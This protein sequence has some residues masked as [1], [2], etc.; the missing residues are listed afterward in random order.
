M[1]RLTTFGGVSLQVGGEAGGAFE[2]R[3][4]PRRGLAVLILL[5]A[6]PPAGLSRDLITTYLWPDSAGERARNTLRQTLFTLRR[7]LGVPDLLVG[8]GPTLSLNPAGLTSDVR[9]LERARAAGDFERVARLYAGPF[10]E[11]FQLPEAPGFWRWAEERR[12]EYVGWAAAA[13]ES[14]ARSA[15]ERH[16]PAA[17][18][19]W[20]RRLAL[21]DPLNTRVV[22]EL[23]AAQVAAGNPALALRHAQ[24]H[25]EQLRRE[26]GAPPD[27]ALTEMVARIRQGSPATLRPTGGGSTPRPGPPPA[28]PA[29]R[30]TERF[31]DQLARELADRFVLEER[32]TPAREDAI[33]LFH[34][35][36][37]R[38]DRNVV[39]KVLHPSLASQLDVERFVRE[40]RLTGRLLHPHILPLLDSGQVGG[41]PW[42]A[43]PDPGG[44]TLRARLTR[45]PRLP[46]DEA[47][48]LTREL[49]EA[50]GYAHAHGVVH[51][52][53]SPDNVLLADGHPL[54]TNLGLARALDTA[55]GRL[56]DTGMLVGAAAYMSPEQ[57]TGEG[58]PDGRSDIYSLGAVLFE[59][60]AG[61]PLFSGPTPQT[62]M[63]KRAAEPTPGPARLRDFTRP[64]ATVLRRSLTGSPEDR[65]RTMG[66]FADALA[67]AVAAGEPRRPWWRGVLKVLGAGRA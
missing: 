1:L 63:A 40:I 28:V 27:R 16:E 44:E 37:R 41:R 64:V 5:A 43:L 56:T 47:A 34:A 21:S 18:A 19:E 62:I 6:G 29:P 33:R 65:Y 3:V 50:L 39:L 60:L 67:D 15:G 7:D 55:A 26:L 35:R 2:E 52:D 61:E 66:E 32:A 14:L 13:V 46:L 20:W 25:E 23:M 57:S 42:F 48:R 38:H 8:T 24:V 31:R 10:L 53:V 51:R 22:L 59:M 45:E 49:A 11:G 36:D 9:D 4:V 17:A 54:L 12:A 58:D 30:G